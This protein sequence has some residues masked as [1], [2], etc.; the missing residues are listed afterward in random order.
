MR[1]TGLA[2]VAIVVV[3]AALAVGA[4]GAERTPI[5]DVFK[6]MKVSRVVPPVPAPDV[7]LPGLD[8]GSIRLADLR[9]EIV[10]VGFFHTT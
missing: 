1:N 2:S 7:A 3:I 10:L 6:G 8:G 9:G 4:R 5:D